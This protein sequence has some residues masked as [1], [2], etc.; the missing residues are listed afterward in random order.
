M[1]FGRRALKCIFPAVGDL[2]VR[3]FHLEHLDNG[4]SLS[5]H[6]LSRHTQGRYLTDS[7]SIIMAPVREVNVIDVCLVSILIYL[8]IVLVRPARRPRSTPVAEGYNKVPEQH[9][10]CLVY[11][12]YTPLELAVFDGKQGAEGRI[13]LA[14]ERRA[15]AKDEKEAKGWREVRLERTVFDVTA[16]RSFYGPGKSS[17]VTRFF[18]LLT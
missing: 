5:S 11:K 7:F 9:P 6:C 18:R 10:Q 15:K 8:I 1:H 16:G 17:S 4:H 12:Q 13:L 2:A 3:T 14:I